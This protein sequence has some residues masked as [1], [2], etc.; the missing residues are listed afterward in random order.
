MAN[1][2]HTYVLIFDCTKVITSQDDDDD[3]AALLSFYDIYLSLKEMSIC[4]MIL[5]R[6]LNIKCM[7]N[8]RGLQ[9]MFIASFFL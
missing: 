4:L 9:I 3:S 7:E 5:I 2:C 1:F 6:L 8:C